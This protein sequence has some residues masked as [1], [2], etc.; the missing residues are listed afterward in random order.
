MLW[1]SERTH[2]ENGVIKGAQ[3]KNQI[4]EDTPCHG[5]LSV[6]GVEWIFCTFSAHCSSQIGKFTQKKKN[7]NNILLCNNYVQ[8]QMANRLLG[9]S[10]YEVFKYV[11][12]ML[13]CTPQT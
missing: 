12:T 7:Q 1:K 13:F 8:C 10:L 11:I 5:N 6:D 4:K 2:F 3:Q 9:L